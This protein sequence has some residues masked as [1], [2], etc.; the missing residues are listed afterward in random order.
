M[1]S[2]AREI[3]TVLTALAK[4]LD[5]APGTVTAASFIAA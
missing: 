4:N 5:A 2:G 3:T 1:G